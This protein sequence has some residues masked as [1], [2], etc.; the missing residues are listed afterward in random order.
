MTP[1]STYSAWFRSLPRLSRSVNGPIDRPN[2]L[3]HQVL[4]RYPDAYSAVE[5]KLQC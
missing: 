3:L 1:A 2:Q 5:L 4:G